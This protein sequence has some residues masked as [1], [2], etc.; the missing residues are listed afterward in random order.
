MSL[1][2]LIVLVLFLFERICTSLGLSLLSAMLAVG[3][4]GTWCSWYDLQA[5]DAYDQARAAR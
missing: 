4:C 1:L 5:I 3:G 2:L